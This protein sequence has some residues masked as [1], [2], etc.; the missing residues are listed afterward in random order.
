MLEQIDAKTFTLISTFVTAAVGGIKKAF[1]TW[2]NGKEEFLALVIPLVMVPAMK[3]GGMLK[4]VSWDNI[5][6][7]AFLTAMGGQFIHDYILNPII[8]R[9]SDTAVK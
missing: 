6:F 3:L 7:W 4:D 1:P 9:K 5:P 2:T 8:K